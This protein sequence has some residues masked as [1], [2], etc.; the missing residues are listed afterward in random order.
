[1]LINMIGT[2]ENGVK[3]RI[4]DYDD[5]ADTA[6]CVYVDELDTDFFLQNPHD[7]IEAPE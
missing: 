3:F 4:I 7:F 6:W 2:L 5:E 1:M